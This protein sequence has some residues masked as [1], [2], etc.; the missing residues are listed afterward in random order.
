MTKAD[1]AATCGLTA[2]AGTFSTY[3]SRLSG[4]SLIDRDGDTVRASDDLFISIE[5]A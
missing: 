5:A 4:N 2:N 1:L 3:L